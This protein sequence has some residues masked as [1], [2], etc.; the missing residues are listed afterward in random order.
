MSGWRADASALLLHFVF[1]A[2][3]TAVG[4]IVVSSTVLAVAILAIASVLA[5]A[6]LLARSVARNHDLV[7]LLCS[8]HDVHELAGIRS[9]LGR[10]TVQKNVSN[11]LAI[12]CKT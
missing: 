1:S 2:L 9:S 12:A 3:A 5:F 7:L 8:F 11:F 4:A 10:Q 6:G